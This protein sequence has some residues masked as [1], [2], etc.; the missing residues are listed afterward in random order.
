MFWLQLTFFATG[1]SNLRLRGTSYSMH[2]RLRK[3]REP[4]VA[5]GLAIPTV[6]DR[7]EDTSI[8]KPC[9]FEYGEVQMY[10]GM[11]GKAMSML[12]KKIQCGKEAKLFVKLST[13]EGWLIKAAT[14]QSRG[15]N[16]SFR[17][18]GLLD[19]LHAIVEKACDG[20]I[21]SKGDGDEDEEDVDPMNDVDAGADG[22]SPGSRGY[23]VKRP[24][25]YKNHAK[26][27][28]VVVEV[29]AICPEDAPA[30]KAPDPSGKDK[31]PSQTQCARACSTFATES[32]YGSALMTWTGPSTI[33][34]GR[35]CSRE[36]RQLRQIR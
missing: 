8:C 6:T 9:R 34:G 15:S 24:R 4:A 30:Q 29:P 11:N 23:G 21:D 18:T 32:R 3:V 16:T 14:G 20:E 13:Q 26:Y 1:G 19:T 12:T 2:P 35:I 10:G 22:D 28:R 7:C 33:C 31:P 17:R 25:Y 36:C 5:G 27:R